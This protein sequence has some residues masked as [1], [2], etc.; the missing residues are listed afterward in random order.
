LFGLGD[1]GAGVRV[2][3]QGQLWVGEQ[4]SQ[5]TAGDGVV[6][7]RQGGQ[8]WETAHQVLSKVMAAAQT[9]RSA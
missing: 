5:T 9:L 3:L 8:A 4:G 1:G 7:E 2:Q 6:V